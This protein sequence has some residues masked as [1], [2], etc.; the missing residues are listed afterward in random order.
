MMFIAR[1]RIRAGEEITIDYGEEHMQ[2]Y[3]RDGCKCPACM[4]G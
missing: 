1:R 2:L 3:F 4:K